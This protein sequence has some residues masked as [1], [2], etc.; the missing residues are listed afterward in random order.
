MSRARHF[1]PVRGERGLR[2]HLS[3]TETL[4]ALVLAPL[5]LARTATRTATSATRARTA[6]RATSFASRPYFCPF[7][8]FLSFPFLSRGAT[9][10]VARNGPSSEARFE[11]PL[12]YDNYDICNW[13]LD[14]SEISSRGV[15]NSL[16]SLDLLAPSGRGCSA[17]YGPAP[18]EG[19][20]PGVRQHA[21]GL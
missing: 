7:H 14:G 5:V 9:V 20:P 16:Y 1:A 19:V 11:T 4:A 13:Q 8:S 3:S 17:P 6:T 2:R 12:I 18:F 10:H 21:F 15:N